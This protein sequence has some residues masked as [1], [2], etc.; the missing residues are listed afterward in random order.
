AT[1]TIDRHRPDML[2]RAA[3]SVGVAGACR[4][5]PP[6]A[7]VRASAGCSP[8]HDVC[9]Y[10]AADD[11]RAETFRTPNKE[12]QL[13]E[14]ELAVCREVAAEAGKL[15]RSMQPGIAAWEKGPADL[16]TEADLA[17]QPLIQRR[18]EAEFPDYG[19]EGEEQTEAAARGST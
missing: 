1:A 9:E 2:R 12:R 18:L 5:P 15:L 13:V 7:I 14:R 3:T 10:W 16:V 4:R 11:L 19:F 8:A 17:A 6:G